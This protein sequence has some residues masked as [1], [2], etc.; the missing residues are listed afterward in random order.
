MIDELGDRM[1]DYESSGTSS[2]LSHEFPMIVRIDGKGFSKYTKNFEKPFDS[3]LTNMMVE[4][5]RCLVK[6]THANF[7]YTQSDEITLI[8]FPKEKA[9]EYMFGGKLSKIN[10]VFASIATAY[11]NK[12]VSNLRPDI[13]KL[14]FFD[15]R[16]WNVPS[17]IEASNAL[18]WRVQDA[19]K[20]SVSALFRWTAGAKAMK[21]LNQAQMKEYL[22]EH[23][24]VDWDNLED[25]YKY[26]TFVKPVVVEKNGVLRTS[27]QDFTDETY[28]GSY[29]LEER[30]DYIK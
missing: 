26:G 15:C 21:N 6:E 29:P 16:S 4:T 24:S 7:G 17:E 27:I 18:L 13:D 22:L 9:T 11:F 28:Y 14:A 19:K 10:S 12:L 3:Q 30:I 8:F 5:T 2:K 25:R 1:K 23:H 20:N